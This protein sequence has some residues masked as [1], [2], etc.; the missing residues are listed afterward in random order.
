MP[1]FLGF[2]DKQTACWCVNTPPFAS[3]RPVVI[4]LDRIARA[5]AV[6][7]LLVST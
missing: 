4:V 6:I 1:P 2:D 3:T 5:I 7:A